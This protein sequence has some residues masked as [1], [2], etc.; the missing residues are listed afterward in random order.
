ME[1]AQQLHAALKL[2]AL[3]TT[4][5]PEEGGVLFDALVSGAAHPKADAAKQILAAE[6]S[7]AHEPVW[8]DLARLPVR[9]TLLD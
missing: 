9:T 1:R 3:M 2:A 8:P 7:A 5:T 4:D 6:I